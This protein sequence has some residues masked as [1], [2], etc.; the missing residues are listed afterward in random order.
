MIENKNPTTLHIPV[1][2]EAVKS[3]LLPA[4]QHST[5]LYLDC[6]L[7]GGGHLAAL[8]EA[9]SAKAWALDRDPQAIAIAAK[10][11][12][13]WISEGR[14]QLRNE[15]FSKFFS[16]TDLPQFSAILADLGY[17]SDQLESPERGLSFQREGPLDMRL[18]PQVGPRAYDLLQLTDE[19]ELRQILQLWGEERMS[20][21][22]ARVICEAV[23]EQRL[24]DSTLALAELIARAV[25]KSYR[26]GRIHPATRTFQALRIWVN[27]ELLALDSLL[28]HAIMMLKPGG[29]LAV[30]SFHSLEDR[31]VKLAFRA[32]KGKG[33]RQI[34]RKPRMAGETEL[35]I[36]PRARSAKLRVIE[37]I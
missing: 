15:D 31:R 5:D 19:V 18:N 13:G 26:Y 2:L 22:I 24:A 34:T 30:I 36:N 37:K 3:E 25:P 16:Q 7:G 12:S 10:R 11:F 32:L 20:G 23:A 6:T 27:G 21:R 14:L 28:K 29:R 8:L 35:N 33:F 9:S 1:L 4:L 17:S